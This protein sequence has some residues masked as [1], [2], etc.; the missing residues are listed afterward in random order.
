MKR[1]PFHFLRA[2]SLK[3]GFGKSRKPSTPKASRNCSIDACQF[4]VSLFVEPQVKFVR[5]ARRRNPG[6]FNMPSNLK[7]SPRGHLRLSSIFADCETE[8]VLRYVFQKCPLPPLTEIQIFQNRTVVCQFPSVNDQTGSR[9]RF[10]PRKF[11]TS[12]LRKIGHALSSCR[13]S[14]TIGASFSTAG[15]H[16]GKAYISNVGDA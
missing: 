13:L 3:S 9:V 14:P 15:I 5:L 11:F 10:L 4:G 7:R 16:D 6:S 1:S 2:S 8:T 12:D